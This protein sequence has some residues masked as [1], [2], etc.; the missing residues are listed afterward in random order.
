MPAQVA[1][2]RPQSNSASWLGLAS[3]AT[4]GGPEKAALCR[5]LGA[6]QAY[7]YRALD[8]KQLITAVREATGG[9]GADVIYDSVGG[10]VFHASRKMIAS[11][12]RLL[13]VGFAS[14]DVAQAPTNQALMANYDIVGVYFGAY[15][16]PSWDAWRRDIWAQILDHYR[17]R[18]LRPLRDRTMTAL[19]DDVAGAVADLGERRT[20]GRVVLELEG[21]S[22]LD[23]GA[24]P[25]S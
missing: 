22:S 23:R 1:S 13:V 6:E 17:A 19:D 2:G 3:L 7:D 16:G 14:G 15:N 25:R 8:S 21:S 12:G 10:D 24:V 18:R 20:T 5:E 4:A 11:E 9:R